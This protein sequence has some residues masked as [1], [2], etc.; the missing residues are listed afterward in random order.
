MK[1]IKMSNDKYCYLTLFIITIIVFILPSIIYLL[2][3][4]SVNGFDGY[5]NWFLQKPNNQIER[6]L[7]SLLFISLFFIINMLYYLITKKSNQIFT[8]FLKTFVFI[9][10]ISLLFLIAIPYTS[11]DVY[12]YMGIGWLDSHYNENPYYVSVENLQD[13]GINDE[14]LQNTGVWKH[15]TSIY[16]PVWSIIIKILTSFSFGNVTFCL[17]IFKFVAL[18]IH[19]L[20]SIL[21]YKITK[22]K[23]IMLIYGLNPLILFE[24]LTNVHN[25][26][27]VIFFIIL[28]IY[29]LIKKNNITLAVISLAI[30]TAIKYFAIL[31]LPF[32]LIY[33]FRK[34]NVEKRI[35]Y[36]IYC[37]IIYLSVLILPYLLYIK[38]MSIFT[39]MMVETDKYIQSI[40]LVVLMFF[41]NI[42]KLDLFYA[43]KKFDLLI[44]AV[45]YIIIVVK[46]LVK[47]KIK[48]TNLMR[49]YNKV[50]LVFMFCLLTNFRIWYLVWLF[51][52]IIWQKKNVIKFE[53]YLTMTC[54]IPSTLYFY[55]NS[56]WYMY[57]IGHSIYIIFMAV[58]LVNIENKFSNR[59][60]NVIKNEYN[61]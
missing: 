27:Y 34:E 16:G 57:G 39:N 58:I 6:I 8:D 22:K 55:L 7:N 1:K 50:L 54:M 14:I 40:A 3:Y 36:S 20:N 5:L 38:D 12:Y 37:G 9:I 32:L 47:H 33:Y 29:C 24:T 42:N 10:I 15:T 25:D 60:I 2:K 52:T 49:E 19:I 31:L 18:F 11:S 43:I 13:S 30:G 26:I 48:F 46:Q 17:Y 41:K 56:E 53:L 59:K 4:N 44:F 21:I 45:F 35:K 61:N 51:P 28:S 23:K